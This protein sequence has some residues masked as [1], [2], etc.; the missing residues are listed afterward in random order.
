MTEFT[1][2]PIGRVVE[3]EADLSRKV[4]TCRVHEVDGR[5]RRLVFSE[6]G[7]Q[8]AGR[9]IRLSLVGPNT[10]K[11]ET[12]ECGAHCRVGGIDNQARRNRRGSNA[13]RTMERPAIRDGR[14]GSACDDYV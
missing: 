3:K 7:L 8:A 11:S 9:R 2:Q 6:H 5:R 1:A 12:V 4:M 10:G 13:V 14:D